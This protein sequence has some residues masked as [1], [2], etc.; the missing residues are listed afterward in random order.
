MG[1]NQH[2]KVCTNEFKFLSLPTFILLNDLFRNVLV[3]HIF[4]NFRNILQCL[5]SSLLRTQ[6]TYDFLLTK[7]DDKMALTYSFLP[8]VWGVKFLLC[9]V[10]C[11]RACSSFFSSVMKGLVTLFRY[12]DGRSWLFC[13]QSFF[14]TVFTG[15][16]NV[17]TF[18]YWHEDQTFTNSFWSSRL[19]AGRSPSE[20]LYNDPT[21]QI[22]THEPIAS[23]IQWT[24]DIDPGT[25]LFQY[26]NC[27]F[28]GN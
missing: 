25:P 2:G 26:T 14:F 4:L 12:I 10:L 27:N 28:L 22:G 6:S 5:P 11:L 13:L 1:A 23:S 7:T 15:V 19:Q 21:F 9:S 20:S 17:S 24:T 16:N 3:L 18:I 8:D